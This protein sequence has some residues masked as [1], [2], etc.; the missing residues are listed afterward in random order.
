MRGQGI[1]RYCGEP[2]RLRAQA[3]GKRGCT[4]IG[5]HAKEAERLETTPVPVLPFGSGFRRPITTH[6]AVVT[7]TT[8]ALV[9]TQNRRS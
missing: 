8:R 2:S 1:T 4:L 5:W 3:A 7:R 6:T 9:T